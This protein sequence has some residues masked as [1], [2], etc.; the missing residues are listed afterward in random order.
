MVAWHL[1]PK[2]HTIPVN[3]SSNFGEHCNSRETTLNMSPIHDCNGS[4]AAVMSLKPPQD[5][6][7]TLPLTKD[8]HCHTAG[9]QY[10]LLILWGYIVLILV[11][12]TIFKHPLTILCYAIQVQIWIYTTFI[13]YRRSLCH[14]DNVQRSGVETVDQRWMAQKLLRTIT[15]T[16]SL[17]SNLID[18]D[19]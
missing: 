3:L 16:S 2:V 6:W 19:I 15:A 1:N 12:M 14:K 10:G 18:K 11:P 9:L 4:T 7:S 17:N 13:P 8:I 5:Q